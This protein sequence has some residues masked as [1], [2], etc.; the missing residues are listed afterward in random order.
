M[1]VDGSVPG[2]VA[3]ESVLV[4]AA[5]PRGAAVTVSPRAGAEIDAWRDRLRLRGGGYLEPSRTALA[6]ARPHVTGGFELRLLRVHA[7]DNRVNVDL[8]WQV[9]VDYAPRYFHGAWLGIN[10]WQHGR[11]GGQVPAE[12][13]GQ[14][15][16]VD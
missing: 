8:A 11:T 3:P 7:L 2:A 16:G 4:G 5:I 10:L 9:G 15:G 13:D 6:G 1:V 14:A 12:G